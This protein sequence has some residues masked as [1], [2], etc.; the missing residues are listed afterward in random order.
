MCGTGPLQVAATITSTMIKI[1]KMKLDKLILPKVIVYLVVF[2]N[3]IFSF[4]FFFFFLSF[5]S[6]QLRYKIRVWISPTN[7]MI[8]RRSISHFNCKKISKSPNH[9]GKFMD[10]FFSQIIFAITLSCF[11]LWWYIFFFFFFYFLFFIFFMVS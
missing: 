5:D 1:T 8:I 6:F 7:K 9:M 4:F 11:E 10:A 3:F 2:F